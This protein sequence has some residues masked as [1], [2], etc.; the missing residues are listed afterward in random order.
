MGADPELQ[1]TEARRQRF[2]VRSQL[3]VLRRYRDRQAAAG[4]ATGRSDAREAE[5][6]RELRELDAVVEGLRAGLGRPHR[7]LP[8]TA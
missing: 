1:L 7:R 5:L 2:F 3:K 4:C 6:E 8:P